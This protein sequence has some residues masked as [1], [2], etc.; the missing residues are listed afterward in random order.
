M[1]FVLIGSY[2]SIPLPVM[3]ACQKLSYEIEANPDR[4]MRISYSP[5]LNDIRKR[6]AQLLG[7]DTDECVI[8][9]NATHGLNTILRNLDWKKEDVIIGSEALFNS[10]AE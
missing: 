2:G 1:S 3:E 9:P 7:A 10:F 8:V 6:V 5:L 4:F